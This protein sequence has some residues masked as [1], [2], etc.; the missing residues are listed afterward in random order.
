[1][2]RLV[3]KPPAYPL[4]EPS[5]SARV[6]HGGKEHWFP[7]LFKSPESHRAYTDLLEVLERDQPPA[8]AD[9]PAAPSLHLISVAERIERFWA[10]AKRYYRKDDRPT[11]EHV[12]IRAALR[13][14]LKLRG[15]M[16]AAQFRPSHLKQVREEMISLGCSRRYF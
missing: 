15:R 4:H 10:H 3:H 9:R 11:G 13:P 1:M 16:I 12:T 7:A 5:G 8:E 2:L 6:R 14:L